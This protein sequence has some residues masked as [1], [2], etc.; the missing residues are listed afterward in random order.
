MQ[1][2][3]GITPPGPSGCLPRMKRAELIEKRQY[4]FC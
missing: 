2:E 4:Y 3:D 1:A